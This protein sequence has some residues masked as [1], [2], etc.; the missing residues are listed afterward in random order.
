VG[1]SA[2]V[3]WTQ[4]FPYRGGEV[5]VVRLDRGWRVALGSDQQERRLLVDAFEALTGHHASQPELAVV[6][7]ALVFDRADVRDST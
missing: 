3:R 5:V 6:G 1:D 2:S 4:A 7:T